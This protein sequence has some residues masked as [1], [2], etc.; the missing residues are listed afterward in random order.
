MRKDIDAGG[1][2]RA[3][4]GWTPPVPQG[5]FEMSTPNV[6]SEQHELKSK[7]GWIGFAVSEANCGRG[8]GGYSA[9]AY[10]RNF[11]PAGGR[12]HSRPRTIG[13]NRQ[14]TLQQTAGP[15]AAVGVSDI[16]N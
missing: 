2:G 4:L 12:E 1:A 7:G 13:V 8:I 14:L 3:S 6:F 16:W 10:F 11:A 5:V 15:L 9:D